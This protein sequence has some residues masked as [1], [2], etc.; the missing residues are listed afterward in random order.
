MVEQVG[1]AFTMLSTDRGRFAEAEREAFVDARV[2]LFAFR[3]VGYEHYRNLLATQPAGD[4]F[5]QRGQA[6]TRIEYEHRRVRAF[7]TDFGLLAH[8]A[9][10]AVGILVFPAG[11][12]DDLELQPRDFR[13]AEA[14]VARDAG[15]VVDQRQP[16]ADE[17]VEQR[18]LAD[19]RA[20]DDDHRGLGWGYAHDGAASGPLAAALQADV[21]GRVKCR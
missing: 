19:I 6:D 13:I 16:L 14:A 9:G 12:V 4:L 20:A 17:P 15:L 7:Q 2:A 18:R 8:P 3:L 11:G 21:R 5:V 1:D 10:Q